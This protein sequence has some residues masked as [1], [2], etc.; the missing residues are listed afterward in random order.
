MQTSPYLPIFELTRAGVTESIH[1][2][3]VAVVDAKGNLV[4]WY[5]DADATTFLRST[6]KPLQVLPFLERG[7]Q[8]HFGL[9]DQE[10]AIMCA[11]HSGTDSHVAVVRSLQSKTGIAEEELLCG[12]HK[13]FYKPAYEAMQKR[14]EA[15]SSNRHNCSGKH[16]GMLAFAKMF[17]PDAA[18]R[19]YIDPEHRIQKVILETFAQMC[20]LQVEQ[21]GV[22][23]DG[24]SA[25]IFSAP[26]QNV[27]L[28]YARLCDPIAGGVAPAARVSACNQVVSAMTAHPE[29]VGGPER[30][31]TLLMEVADGR[32]L[33]K[34][35]AEAFQGIGI[36]PGA[37]GPDSPA[38]G[39]AIKISDGDARKK[40]L[41][42][43][44]METLRQL[45]ALSTEALGEL[46]RFGPEL[47]VHNWRKLVVGTAQPVFNLQFAPHFAQQISQP[48]AILVG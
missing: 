23:V 15:L 21:V 7:G 18:E 43:V 17:Q 26:L 2:G 11:S 22:G 25:P 6:A 33:S 20:F 16:S 40:A 4:A 10:I 45:K 19:F 12:V 37:L 9:S 38:L 31:D 13:P 27:A 28:A 44:A 14:G 34:G 3:A 24:C 30:F 48:D 46:S 47:P 1:N 35:G 29:M 36:M 8:Q 32:I 5:A 39:I 42:A 41:P